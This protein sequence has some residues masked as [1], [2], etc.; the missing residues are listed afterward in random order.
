MEERDFNAAAGVK[1]HLYHFD[2]ATIRVLL[3]KAGL[4]LVTWSPR[5]GGKHVSLGFLVER[6]GRIHPW[7]S[8]LL[9]PLKLLARRSLYVNVFDEMLVVAR[10]KRA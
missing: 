2:P 9:A 10:A 3:E 7:L 8:T 6:A 4:E 1:E 5:R